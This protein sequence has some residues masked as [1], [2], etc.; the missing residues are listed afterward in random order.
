MSQV[1]LTESEFWERSNRS[2]QNMQK[3]ILSS[4]TE[5][6]VRQYICAELVYWMSLINQL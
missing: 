4:R 2:I 6:G 1:R 5:Y 3:Y